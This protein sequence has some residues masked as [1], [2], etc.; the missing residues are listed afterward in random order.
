M[1]AISLAPAAHPLIVAV[2]AMG[3]AGTLCLATDGT[4]NAIEARNMRSW[5]ALRK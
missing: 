3:M 1:S 4:K 5:R 2:S